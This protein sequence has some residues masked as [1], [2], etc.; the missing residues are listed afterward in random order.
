MQRHGLLYLPR[1]ELAA[2]RSFLN[3]SRQGDNDFSYERWQKALDPSAEED[4]IVDLGLVTAI[5][6]K[7][8]S[9]VKRRQFRLKARITTAMPVVLDVD[10]DDD[11]EKK[12]DQESL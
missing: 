10:K 9:A 8:S 11:E 7:Q 2:I 4:M 1:R 12:K 3:A 6:P 5:A